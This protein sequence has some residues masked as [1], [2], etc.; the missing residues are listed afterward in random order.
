MNQAKNDSHVHKN[1]VDIA[2]ARMEEFKIKGEEKIRGGEEYSSIRI[3]DN[4]IWNI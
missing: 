1:S 4:R 3:S 2:I